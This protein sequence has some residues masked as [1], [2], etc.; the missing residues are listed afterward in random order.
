MFAGDTLF[1]L[2]SALQLTELEREG[3]SGRGLTSW[4]CYPTSGNY[5]TMH[6]HFLMCII[7]FVS[8]C[9]AGVCST[10]L[11]VCTAARPGGSTQCCGLLSHHH[12]ALCCSSLWL[13]KELPFSLAIR[14]NWNQS[15]EKL[16]LYILLHTTTTPTH[17]HTHPHI[18][19]TTHRTL[20]RSRWTTPPCLS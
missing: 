12:C 20:T 16:S 1:E 5:T 15:I 17:P 2:R 3:V 14:I 18:T 7:L 8:P 10:H 4:R 13:F 6:I 11:S 19:H 9:H